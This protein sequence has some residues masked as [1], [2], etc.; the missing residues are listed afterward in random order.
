MP[1]N[2]SDNDKVLIRDAFEVL[3]HVIVGN[4]VEKGWRPLHPDLNERRNMGEMI[5]LLH[6]EVSE[7]FESYRNGEVALWYS[8]HGTNGEPWKWEGPQQLTDQE[9]GEKTLGKPEGIA[10]EL[11]DVFIRMIDMADEHDIPLVQ[12]IFEKH[13]YNTTRPYR[14]GN[15]RA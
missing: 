14:H 10:S 5:A 7:A 2:L 11:A 6:S 8:G 1:N 3:E 15:K 12:A 4:N 13:F 9:T